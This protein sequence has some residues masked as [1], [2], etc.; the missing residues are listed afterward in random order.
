MGVGTYVG[1]AAAG[2]AAFGTMLFP[3]VGT[4]GGAAIGAAG[5][6]VAGAVA[7]SI[8]PLKELSADAGQAVANGVEDAGDWAGDQVKK[9][10]DLN[11]L[12]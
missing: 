11:P 2:G 1:G 8:D 6:L 3:G 10:P 5:G 7:A 9:L 4:L 12:W